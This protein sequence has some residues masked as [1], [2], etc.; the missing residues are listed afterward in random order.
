MS[1]NSNQLAQDLKNIVGENY[2]YTDLAERISYSEVIS[3]CDLERADLSDIVVLPANAQEI[4]EVL[5]YANKHKIPINIFGSGT[6][7]MSKLKHKGIT[8]STERLNFLAIDEDCQWVECGAGV[9]NGHLIR[10][11]D[12]LGYFFQIRTQGGSRHWGCGKY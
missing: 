9:K 12:R 2:V 3:P 7:P 4:S 11:L 10:E 8:L 6:S 1:V 5:K